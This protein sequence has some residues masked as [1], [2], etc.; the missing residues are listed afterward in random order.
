M[1][2]VSALPNQL[3]TRKQ[4]F[5]LNDAEALELALPVADDG[6]RARGVLLAT[7]TWLVALAFDDGWSVIERYD[8][9]ETER[10]DALRAGERAVEAELD[11]DSAKKS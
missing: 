2:A 7:E 9:T 1:D 5:A 8:L 3:L 11:V 6:R 4:L 10:I